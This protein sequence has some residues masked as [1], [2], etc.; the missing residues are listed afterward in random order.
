M[1]VWPLGLN[2]NIDWFPILLTMIATMA[3]FRFK[4]NVNPVILV[5]GL[6]GMLYKLLT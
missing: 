5:S 1:D 4:V 2:V 6:F 3:I